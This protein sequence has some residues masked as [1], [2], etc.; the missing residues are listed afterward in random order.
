MVCPEEAVEAVATVEEVRG[1]R[2]ASRMER[3]RRVLHQPD[4]HGPS[5]SSAIPNVKVFARRL[6]DP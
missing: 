4:P 1:S 5:P 6:L 2:G 3:L